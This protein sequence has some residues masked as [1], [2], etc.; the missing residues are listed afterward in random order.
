M[1]P[2]KLYRLYIIFI[3]I[4]TRIYIYAREDFFEQMATMAENMEGKCVK[5]K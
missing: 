3:N 4:Y 2:K 1:L 5:V